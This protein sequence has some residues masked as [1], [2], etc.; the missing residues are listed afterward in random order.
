M[1]VFANQR[2]NCFDQ[3]GLVVPTVQKLTAQNHEMK[4]YLGQLHAL[5][6]DRFEGLQVERLCTA[7]VEFG[8]LAMDFQVAKTTAVVLVPTFDKIHVM[9]H[10][11][12]MKV[13]TFQEG[14][15]PSSVH[16]LGRC[17]CSSNL[18]YID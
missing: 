13:L 10:E 5:N 9:K 1:Q 2:M 14:E 12:H 16:D 18:E 11:E 17:R 7:T 15:N 8:E 6:S 3:Q 4:C